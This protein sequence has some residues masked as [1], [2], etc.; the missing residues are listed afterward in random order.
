MIDCLDD[1]SSAFDMINFTEQ[2]R[3]RGIF[4]VEDVEFAQYESNGSLTVIKKGDGSLSYVL[5]SKGQIVQDQLEA[6]GQSEEWLT[7]E[8]E[9]QGIKLEDI[10][11][12]ELEGREKIYIVM[13]DMTARSFAFSLE[14]S[15]E[16]AEQKMD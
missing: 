11:F 9:H 1:A 8:L 13:N 3:S 7:K 12:A 4:S 10:F 6:S 15:Q 14:N 2:L 16:N 5:V